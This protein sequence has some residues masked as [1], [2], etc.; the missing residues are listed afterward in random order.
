MIRP[1]DHIAAMAPY[2]LASVPDG[3]GVQSLSQNECFRPPTPLAIA[4]AA[5][6]AANAALYPDPDCTAL[7]HALGAR[8]NV[9]PGTIVVGAGS[10]D[11]IAALVRIY[12]GP[13]RSV[14]APA[15]AYPFIRTAAQLAAARLDL[16]P[17]RNGHVD[18][19]ALL[20][21]VSADTGIVFIANPANPTGTRL[22]R[23]DLLRLRAGL[24]DDI[25]LILDEAYGEFADHLEPPDCTVI[26]SGNTAVL[27]TF[28][29][30]YGLAGLRVGWGVFPPAVA[31]ELRKVQSPNGVSA[32]SQAAALAALGDQ[33][34]MQA[35]CQET[36]RLRALA[37]RLLGQ[38]GFT[39]LPSHTNFVLLDLGT[40]Q[41]AE[42]ADAVL[43]AA[44]LIA[45]RQGG[46]G[47]PQALRITSGP[48][49][50]LMRAIETL[51]D[52]NTGGRT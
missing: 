16:A 38:A 34:Y 4:A 29:K 15:H 45:R 41:A 1:A 48:E 33:G 27:R 28:S 46:A 8:H 3:D 32:P 7:R 49:P 50:A 11:L 14:L 39:V 37:S 5:A 26:D 19:G 43:R 47:L 12:A 17:E 21:A 20:A 9:D 22:P 30:A 13:G 24:R 36:A 35:T 6:A 2:A 40:A 52:W 18:T 25:L 10:L 51:I 44:G 23:A 42:R 31:A